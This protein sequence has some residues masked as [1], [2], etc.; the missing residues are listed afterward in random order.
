MDI[1][2]LEILRRNAGKEE[3]QAAMELLRRD[4]EEAAKITFA[5][6]AYEQGEW[7]H[8]YHCDEDG[9]RLTFQW[10]EPFLHL[11][12]TCGKERRS[13]LLDGCWT[14]IAHSRIGQAVYHVAVLYALEPDDSRLQFVK[15]YLMAYADHYETYAIHGNIP[16]NGPGKLFAQTLDEAH[17]I[18]DLALAFDRIQDH[19]SPDEL[20]HI[21][22]GLLEPCAR[23][24]IAHK[25]EQIHNH[26]VLITS[27]IAALGLLLQD[28]TMLAAALDGEYGLHD[29]LDR[30]I[31]EDGLWYEGNV[32]YHFYALKSLLH[33]ALI[34]EGTLWDVWKKKALKAMF[35]YPLQLV[36]PNGMM[37]TLNDAGLGHHIGTYV[38]YY[39]IA[40]DRYGDD[41]YRSLL[42]TAYGTADADPRIKIAKPTPRD[43]IY[44]LMFGQDL[45][46]NTAELDSLG[47]EVQRSRSLTA[48]GLTKL[49]NE[50][51][52]HV[53]VKHSRFGGEHD[54]MD[55][56]GLSVMHSSIPLLVDPGTTAYGVPAHYGWFKHTYSHNTVSMDGADQPPRDGRLIQMH[57]EPWGVWLETAVDWL[58]EEYAMKDRIIL[59]A[60]LN[61]WDADAYQGVQMRRIN[62]LAEDHLLDIIQVTVAVPRV[63]HWT[64]HFS[65]KLLGRDDEAQWSKSDA[66]LGRLDQRWFKEKRKLIADVSTFGYQM[67]EGTLEQHI[68]CSLPTN[69]YTALTPDNPPSGQ[70]TSLMTTAFVERRVICVQALHYDASKG[71]TLPGLLEVTELTNETLQISWNH[72]ESHTTY[73]IKLIDEKVYIE[74]LT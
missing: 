13:Q 15:S 39:E 52:W 35:D 58:A 45:G 31:M 61:P 50:A 70:R 24:L 74:K 72:A 18:T 23:F 29:Q 9:T 66:P 1:K 4:A 57:E 73:A 63:V 26:S 21:R 8:D 64:N 60:E 46:G 28:R 25:E 49:V 65:G 2:R 71:E 69:I 53:I 44:A 68:W 51:G 32:Q 42:N 20:A 10:D 59:P 22:A 27:A 33:Y 16:Y 54:H 3:F 67:R 43:S 11:C 30:G 7:T 55:R 38:P 12:S 19:L 40:Y 14:S 56:L 47:A 5:V 6:R 36:M 17:W 48:S 41:K 37:P 62:L 34:A